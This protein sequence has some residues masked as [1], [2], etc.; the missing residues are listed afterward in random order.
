MF[1]GLT[2]GILSIST[3]M[4]FPSPLEQASDGLGDFRSLIVMASAFIVSLSAYR[5]SQRKM[6]ATL[7]TSS[8]AMMFALGVVFIAFIVSLCLVAYLWAS[9]GF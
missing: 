2:A 7:P 4:L 9:H 3:L 5:R 6:P 1:G 8:K